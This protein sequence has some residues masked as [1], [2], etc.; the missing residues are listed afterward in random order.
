MLTKTLHVICILIV[1]LEES[2]E[3]TEIR[4]YMRK[5]NNN[6][7]EKEFCVNACFVFTVPVQTPQNCDMLEYFL[8]IRNFRKDQ[9]GQVVYKV[10]QQ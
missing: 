10:R 5:N 8:P 9:P 2:K 3:T 4:T 7:L 1:I 6:N